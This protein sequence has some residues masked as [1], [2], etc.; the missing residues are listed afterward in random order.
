VQYAEQTLEAEDAVLHNSSLSTWNSGYTGSGYV[1]MTDA[2]S[3]YIE[4]TVDVGVPA[5]ANLSFRHWTDSSNGMTL[6]VNG[7]V[8]DAAYALSGTGGQ[9]DMS[10]V[11]SATLNAGS[12]TVRL[13]R[14]SGE[15]S[16]RIDHLKVHS[17]VGNSQTPAEVAYQTWVNEYNLPT[18]AA[19]YVSN[20]DGDDMNNLAE[21]GL[22]GNPMNPDDTGVQP[23][24]RLMKAADT[25]FIEYVYR[26]RS[27]HEARGLAY[28][29]ETS[30]NLQES[31][32]SSNLVIEIGSGPLVE[33]FESVTNRLPIDDESQQY[34]RLKIHSE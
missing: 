33:G 1:V 7:E 25:N 20:P 34:I 5:V 23:D 11:I 13:A 30:T 14:N 15:D 4:W 3:S 9:W 18:N 17:L 16:V 31:S 28:W 6:K 29:L 21:Y 26:R 10:A 19:A 24:W 22:G 27:D 12:N 32:W 8:V 2:G